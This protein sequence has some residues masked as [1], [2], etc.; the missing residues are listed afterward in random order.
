MKPG[1]RDS[2]KGEGRHQGTGAVAPESECHAL[3][4]RAGLDTNTGGLSTESLGLR[5][6]RK[7]DLPPP[8]TEV[9]VRAPWLLPPSS[10]T[11]PIR[12]QFHL[13]SPS[14]FRKSM[15]A[16][17]AFHTNC[18]IPPPPPPS[19]EGLLCLTYP[20]RPVSTSTQCLRSA[21]SHATH[22]THS[23]F[24]NIPPGLQLLHNVLSL[25]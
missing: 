23:G 13:P 19:S 5:T 11:L 25:T 20:F 1:R 7:P 24:P 15:V 9:W 14:S 22:S 21:A 2:L 8:R 10:L 3:P 16:P 6:G 4:S 17:F 18:K 12:G